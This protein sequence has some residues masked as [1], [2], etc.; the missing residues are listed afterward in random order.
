MNDLPIVYL[1]PSLPRREAA[2][3]LRADYRPPVRRGDLKAV[4]GALLVVIIDGEF[5]Q[6]LSVSPKE[7]LRLLDEGTRVLGASSMG[8]LRAAE[9]FPYGME[10]HGWIFEN[11]QSGRI[12]GDDEVALAYSPIDQS[13]LTVPLVNVRRWLET[14]QASGT[15]DGRTARQMFRQARAIFFADRTVERL[16]DSFRPI[17]DGPV[18]ARVLRDYYD[19]TD[20]KAADARLVLARAASISFTHSSREEHCYGN[21]EEQPART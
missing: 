15:L 13:P 10:G 3:I 5:G 6:N 9:L 12:T 21:Q 20:V 17:L 16:R 19:I 18:L 1:G 7:I 14:L 11:Y 2:E 8:A 4:E